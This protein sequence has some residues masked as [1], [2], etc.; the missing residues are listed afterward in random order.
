[1]DGTWNRST[2]ISTISLCLRPRQRGM[3]R[4]GFS[5]DGWVNW[6][7]PLAVQT[8]MAHSCGNGVSAI[9]T[10]TCIR[11]PRFYVGHVRASPCYTVWS[12][13]SFPGTGLH[14]N[15]ATTSAA[16]SIA[17]GYRKSGKFQTVKLATCF[18]T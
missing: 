2:R 1:M 12:I 7:M 6:G 4:Q 5:V 14:S 8:I 16:A 13:Q 10:L 17:A 15:R 18:S 9:V 3:I 11:W